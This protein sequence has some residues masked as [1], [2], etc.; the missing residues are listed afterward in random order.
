M[1][2]KQTMIAHQI[3]V[4]HTPLTTK[5]IPHIPQTTVI[6]HGEKIMRLS[7]TEVRSPL[8]VIPLEMFVMNMTQR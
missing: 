2:S 7:H 8:S 1:K 4:Y 6:K 3:N 5:L